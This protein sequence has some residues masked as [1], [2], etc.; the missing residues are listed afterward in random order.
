MR[1]ANHAGLGK[2][3]E[4]LGQ[5][6]GNVVL[7]ECSRHFPP[8]AK[9]GGLLLAQGF[10]SQGALEI[11]KGNRNVCLAASLS[12]QAVPAQITATLYCNHLWS[13]LNYGLERAVR[14]V[15]G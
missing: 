14:R 15:P 13:Y 4:L 6:K 12:Q 11:W 7:E 1:K 5:R 2:V 10:E 3:G 8:L 9:P